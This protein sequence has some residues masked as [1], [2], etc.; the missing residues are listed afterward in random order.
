MS[1]RSSAI[2]PRDRPAVAVLDG[3]GHW[4]RH[5]SGAIKQ[6]VV[7][8]AEVRAERRHNE[9]PE[10]GEAS[11]H[12]R[13]LQDMKDRDERDTNRISSTAK[14]GGRMFILDTSEL[15]ADEAFEA[16]LAVAENSGR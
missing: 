12:A 8:S 3:R 7:A 9:L 11:I 13:V 10:R 1:L 14:A 2:L 15:N 5:L 16:A 4:H 6:H